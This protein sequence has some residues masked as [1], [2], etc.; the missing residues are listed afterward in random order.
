VW[1][2]FPRIGKASWPFKDLDEI[3]DFDIDWAQRL[4][5]KRSWRCSRRM[6]D[7]GIRC[8]FFFK[9]WSERKIVERAVRL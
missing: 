2:F 1:P 8:G 7:E 5:R 9:E 3:L 4:S 6:T